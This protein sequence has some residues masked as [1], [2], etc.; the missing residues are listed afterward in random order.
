MLGQG[1]MLEDFDKGLVGAVAGE[2]RTLNFAFPEGYGNDEIAGKD[3]EFS[4]TVKAVEEPRL[5]ELDDAFA[6]TLGISEGG[7]EKMREEIRINLNRELESR[8]RTELR[9]RVMDALYAANEIPA[10]KALVEEEV[11]R[12]V[13]MVKNQLESQGLPTDKI[14]PA[15]YEDDSRKRVILGLIA[16]DIIQKHEIQ[17]DQDAIR[18]RVEAMAQSYQDPEEFVNWHMAD[19]SRLQ[20]IEAAVIEDRIVEKMLETATVEPEKLSFREFM[21]PGEKG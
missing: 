21:N 2:T 10:P 3:V 14:D 6:E 11:N 4:V 12:S 16:R 7:L 15:V 18:E 1:Q 5:P 17:P 19:P 8:L 13:E 9:D 20:Q